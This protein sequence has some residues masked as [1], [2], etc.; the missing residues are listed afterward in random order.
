MSYGHGVEIQGVRAR[1]V[2]P[3]VFEALDSYGLPSGVYIHQKD[4]YFGG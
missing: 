1:Y 4:F 2:A 3:G